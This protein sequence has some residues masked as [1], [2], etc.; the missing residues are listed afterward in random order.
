MV[1]D[2]FRAAR[3]G[4]LSAEPG[5]AAAGADTS[6]RG[7][8]TLPEE[9]RAEV[10]RPPGWPTGDADE[11]RTEEPGP[12]RPTPATDRPRAAAPP[13][14][15]EPPAG[16]Q[17]ERRAPVR[18]QGVAAAGTEPATVGWRRRVRRLTGG[19]V[20]PRPSAAER[21][22]R[23]ARAVVRSSLD[24]SLTVVFAHPDAS[25]DRTPLRAA[26]TFGVLRGGSVVAWAVDGPGMPGVPAGQEPAPGTVSD[27]VAALPRFDRIEASRSDLAAFLQPQ[28]SGVDVLPVAPGPGDFA[29]VHRVL[30]R[31]YPIMCVAAGPAAPVSAWAAVA[32]VLVVCCAPTQASV[33]A[34][35]QLLAGLRSAGHEALVAGAVGVVSAAERKVSATAHRM[36][37]GQLRGE[38]RVAAAIPYDRGQLAQERLV[39]GRLAAPADPRW[40]FFCASIIDSFVNTDV[41]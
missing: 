15:V 17:P 1:E 22:L 24:R 20:A 36:L 30:R 6:G 21:R 26:G 41:K 8:M 40:T 2:L 13:P 12:S 33:D 11:W 16:E 25:A 5:L 23:A 19:I 39:H 37:L 38:V 9:P 18:P 34:G 32:D 31:Y 28:P 27:L 7:W 35:R 29:R 3:R 4:A 14:S 10:T